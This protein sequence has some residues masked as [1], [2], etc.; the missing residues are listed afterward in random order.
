M[1]YFDEENHK[2]FNK[3]KEEYISVT[4]LIGLYKHE[5]DK[6]YWSLYKAYEKFKNY[7]KEQMKSFRISNNV[8]LSDSADKLLSVI[9]ESER[10]E[11]LKLKEEIKNEWDKKNKESIEKG[12]KIHKAKEEHDLTNNQAKKFIDSLETTRIPAGKYVE[13]MLYNHKYKIAGTADS[14][15]VDKHENVTIVDY[16]SNN[17]LKSTSYKMMKPPLDSLPDCNFTHYSLQLSIYAYMLEEF[18]Y[19]IKSLQIYHVKEGRTDAMYEIP[20]VRLTVEEMLNHY[21]EVYG[22]NKSN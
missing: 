17:Q 1:I 5:F 2:Y 4:K 7:D 15:M 10:D 8:L 3:D 20:Y 14:V 22:R 6:E 9:P 19:K 21:S 11:V 13:I 16:K 18:G 12:K